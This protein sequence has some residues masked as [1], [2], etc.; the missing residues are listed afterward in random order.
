MGVLTELLERR[1]LTPGSIAWAKALVNAGYSSTT[2]VTVSPDR[3]LQS[4]AVFACIR[5]LSE[6]IAS[7]P[8]QVYRRMPGR[9]KERAPDH[10]LYELLHD[11]PNPEMTSFEF[12]ETLMGHVAGWGNGMAEIEI[13]GAGRARALWPLRPD[14]TQ[15]RRINGQ[16]TYI[17]RLPDRAGGGM[18]TIPSDRVLHIRGLG[19]D[20]LVGYSVIRYARETIGLAIAL[21]EFGARFFANDASP[22]VALLHPQKLSDDAFNHLKDSWEGFHMGLENKHRMAILEEGMKV[23]K[24]GIPPEEAQFLL[25]RKFQVAEVC[26]W[27]RMQPHKIGDLENATFCLPGDAIVFTADGPQP[28]REVRAGQRIWSWD[29]S[30]LQW[31]VGR[32]ARSL[33]AGA[34]PILTIRTTH[35]TVRMNA[36]HRILVRRPLQVPAVASVGGGGEG[37]GRYHLRWE[38]AWTAAGDIHVGD[39]LIGL[40]RLPDGTGETAPTR[41]VSIEFMEFCGYYLGNGNLSSAHGLATG[42]CL[43]HAHD[44]DFFDHYRAATG[45]CFHKRG[46]KP[47]HPSESD[48][49]TRFASRAAAEEILLL[50]LGGTARWKRVPGWVFALRPEYQLALLRGFLDSDGSVDKKGRIGFSSA[51]R[52]LLEG[53]R[54]LC[55]GLGVPVT[56]L[57]ERKGITRLPNGRNVEFHQF[58]F[59]CSDPAANRRIAS[60]I[61][62]YQQRLRDGKPFSRKGRSYPRHGGL[63]FDPRGR[64]LSRVVSISVGPVEDVYDLEV[65]GSH[66]FVADG[67]I[68]H[69]SNIEHQAIEHVV[70][71]IR[72]WTIRWEQGLR[73]SVF[74]PGERA[75]FFAEFLLDGLLRGDTASRYTAYVAAR[76][77]GWLSANDIRELENMNPIDGGDVYLIPL[78]MVPADQVGADPAQ[79]QGNSSRAPVESREMRSAIARRRLASAYVRTLA[80]AEARVLRR[81][82]NDVRKLAKKLLGRRDLQSF[83]QALVG[84]YDEHRTFIAREMLPVFLSYAETVAAEAGQEVLGKSDEPPAELEQFVRDYVDAFV[85]RHVGSSIGQIRDVTRSAAEASQD[86]LVAL[87]ERFAEWEESRPART[88][89]WETIQSGNAVAKLVY[90]AAGFS[91]LRWVSLGNACTYCQSLNGKTARV[92]GN[93]LDAGSSLQPDGAAAPL[94]TNVDIGHPP[95]HPG[96]DCQIVAS[97][98]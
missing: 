40:D 57:Y 98:E 24:I 72:P 96:C 16:L 73:R 13:D 94:T 56:N 37:T 85:A 44:D 52:R 38:D 54:H 7:L 74:L 4:S 22:G 41:R 42:I 70:D 87:E 59:T 2:G 35:R 9:G 81:E 17:V 53:M 67:V 5:V 55:M 15:V 1:D 97:R 79:T 90:V 58:Y 19:F 47:V 34:D 30:D 25:S 63:D 95:A 61:P 80:Q 91:I 26:R 3:A 43:A 28:I 10:Y 93:F 21:E 51:S 88:A 83:D 20:G 89:E 36:K 75:V 6:T 77:N 11:Q 46:G 50:G 18:A 27:F 65:E 76:Q 39:T 8:L 82:I 49:S 84:F 33:V 71:T 32:V 64:V 12:R 62:R 92:D 60:H 29:E 45:Q 31:V 48:R 14:Q 86:F 78:N 68:V 66:T 69:N 23:E